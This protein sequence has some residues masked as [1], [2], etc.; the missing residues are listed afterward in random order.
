MP[1]WVD[2]RQLNDY[3]LYD[4]SE[5]Q[6]CAFGMVIDS[7]I[8]PRHLRLE[9]ELTYDVGISRDNLPLQVHILNQRATVVLSEIEINLDLK[10]DGKWLGI[11]HENEI[12][13]TITQD[14]AS[15]LIIDPGTYWLYLYAN[16]RSSRN[17]YGIVEITV[18]LFE[19][20]I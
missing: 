16:D 20:E 19:K 11:P 6:P 3:T 2:Q 13:Y 4:E 1:T 18:R 12:D 9:M 10:K 5:D 17:I 15:H 8:D 7:I 14:I